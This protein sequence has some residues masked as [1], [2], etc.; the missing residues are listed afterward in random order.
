MHHY[1]SASATTP[2]FCPTLAFWPAEPGSAPRRFDPQT[3]TYA[4]LPDE[5]VIRELL[6][7][8]D[9]DTFQRDHGHLWQDGPE[10]RFRHMR[11]SARYWVAAAL[12]EEDAALDAGV[13]EGWERASSLRSAAAHMRDTVNRELEAFSL[14]LVEVSSDGASEPALSVDVLQVAALQ[15]AQLTADGLQARRCTNEPC[16]RAF[17]RQRSTRRKTTNS[18][19]YAGTAHAAGVRYCSAECG[20]AQQARER[21]RRQRAEKGTRA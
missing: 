2:R 17:V 7:A 1:A 12:G 16:G 15:L 5:F 21:R 9:L 8:P 20:K 3:S 14:R 6:A 13:P 4:A 19:E 11:A 18:G 10:L